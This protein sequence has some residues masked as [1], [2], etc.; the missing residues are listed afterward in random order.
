MYPFKAIALTKIADM[1]AKAFL[2]K[3][4]VAPF[5]EKPCIKKAEDKCEEGNL[6]PQKV[7]KES[8]EWGGD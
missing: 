3:R 2:L 8:F 6:S 1:D 5:F 4:N 7:A